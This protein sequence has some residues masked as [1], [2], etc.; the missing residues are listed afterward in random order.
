MGKVLQRVV[1]GAEVRE[2][3]DISGE[4][5]IRIEEEACCSAPNTQRRDEISAAAAHV[6]HRHV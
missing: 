1:E 3:K 2:N 4:A 5:K 6:A